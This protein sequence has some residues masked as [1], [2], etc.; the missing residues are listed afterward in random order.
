[1]LKYLKIKDMDLMCPV[2][3]CDT[4]GD[5][6]APPTQGNVV[7]HKDDLAQVRHV[8]K[9]G[10]RPGCDRYPTG[11]DWYWDELYL[12]MEQLVFNVATDPRINPT[13]QT[14]E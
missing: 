5:V 3:A 2:I 9:S 7:W 14:D 10:V 11:G 4:C 12:F 8:H 1:M 13:A 6:I